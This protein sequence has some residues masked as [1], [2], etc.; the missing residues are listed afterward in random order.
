MARLPN[1]VPVTDLRQDAAA[2]LRRV[3][4]DARPTIITQRGRAA[5]VLVSIEAYETSQEERAILQRLALGEREVSEGDG[6]DLDDVLAEADALLE[7][8]PQ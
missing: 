2:V 1:V 6:I 7:R 5:A 3:R 8:P 4:E